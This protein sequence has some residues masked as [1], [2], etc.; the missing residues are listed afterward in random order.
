MGCAWTRCDCIRVRARPA[1]GDGGCAGRAWWISDPFCGRKPPIPSVPSAKGKGR[2]IGGGLHPTRL[3]VG[4]I[5][6]Q[7]SVGLVSQMVYLSRSAVRKIP[8]MSR[9]LVTLH[10]GFDRLNA[11]CPRLLSPARRP[12]SVLSAMPGLTA[13]PRMDG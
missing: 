4:D 11:G 8:G 3:L 5:A 7:D 2:R 9:A 13:R 10:G 1:A 12:A 6:L